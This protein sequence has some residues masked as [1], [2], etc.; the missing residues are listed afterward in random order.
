VQDQ[1]IIVSGESGAGKTETT[2]HVLEYLTGAHA[3]SRGR[4]PQP[5]PQLTRATLCPPEMSNSVH[6]S[7]NDGETPLEDQC[8]FAQTVRGVG[9]ESKSCGLF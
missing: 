2:K 7:K 9:E 6:P 5:Q 3:P 1:S 8:L 4:W